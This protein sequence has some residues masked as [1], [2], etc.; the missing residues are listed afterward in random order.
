MILT[1]RDLAAEPG[2][3][4]EPVEILPVVNILQTLYTQALAV[5]KMGLA[6]A[7]MNPGFGSA[8]KPSACRLLLT[9][10]SHRSHQYVPN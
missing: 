1:V 3:K 9:L 6:F 5:K 2:G 4:R 8:S 7:A 10:H